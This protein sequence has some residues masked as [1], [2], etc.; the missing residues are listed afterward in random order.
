MIGR[1][2][3]GK[4]YR[5]FPVV[6]SEAFCRELSELVQTSPQVIQSPSFPPVHWPAI[7]TRHGTACLM[8]VW[9]DLAVDPLQVR[10]VRE[11]F[12][13]SRAAE[14]G[15]ILTGNLTIED[16]GEHFEPA[17]GMFQSVHL[18][19]RFE[20]RSGA[21]VATYRCSFAFP[22]AVSKTGRKPTGKS[23]DR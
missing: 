21:P 8:S 15:E 4:A 2:F 17:E 3:I 9:E 19:V 13:H 14:F 6:L 20:D 10:L 7:L 16:V 1:E 11:E 23:V 12:D 22:L 18:Q 5:P